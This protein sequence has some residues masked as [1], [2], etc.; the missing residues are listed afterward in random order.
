ML[1]ASPSH[2]VMVPASRTVML[3]QVVGC[4]LVR[5]ARTYLYSAIIHKQFES[6]LPVFNI[7]YSKIATEYLKG[8]EDREWFQCPWH[9]MCF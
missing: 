1:R 3:G 6:K 4:C 2:P 5:D 7:Q 8:V 9:R